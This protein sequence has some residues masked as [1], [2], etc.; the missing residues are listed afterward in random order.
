MRGTKQMSFSEIQTE[1]G[2]LAEQLRLVSDAMEKDQTWKM[3][4]DPEMDLPPVMAK[5][6]EA[7]STALAILSDAPNACVNREA[8]D[9]FQWEVSGAREVMETHWAREFLTRTSYAI[10]F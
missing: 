6:M 4:G 9:A 2:H 8:L 5:T 7:V 3:Y 10:A 1:A